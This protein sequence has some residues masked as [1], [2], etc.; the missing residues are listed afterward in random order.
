MINIFFRKSVNIWHTAHKSKTFKG[1]FKERPIFPK[2]TVIYDVKLL[3]DFIKNLGCSDETSLKIS[4]KAL[5]TLMS[6]LSGLRSQT[7]SS[8]KI[9]SMY[10]NEYR[11]IFFIFKLLK[12]ARPG[13]Y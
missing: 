9:N 4:T 13:F 5:A 8:L 1:M 12:S 6:L 2:Y 11:S 7:L 10:I 3:L